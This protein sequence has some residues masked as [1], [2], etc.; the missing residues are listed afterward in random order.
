MP[1]HLHAIFNLADVKL[2]S[3]LIQSF[4]SL[5]SRKA[6]E[7]GVC[8]NYEELYQ[9]GSFRLWKPRFDDFIIRTPEQ[10]CIKLNYIHE[11]PVRAGI[12]ESAVD[13]KYSSASDWLDD[14]NGL[15]EINRDGLDFVL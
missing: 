13:F 4:K 7:L 2:L 1:S 3:R 15:I 5:S 10:F 14:R 6:K 8:E 12:V 9:K 11:N